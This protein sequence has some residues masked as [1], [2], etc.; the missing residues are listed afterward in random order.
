MEKLQ[1]QGKY[2]NKKREEDEREET[3]QKQKDEK[4]GKAEQN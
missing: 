3:E 2:T 4:N 1:I